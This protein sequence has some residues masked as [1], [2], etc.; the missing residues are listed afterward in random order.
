MFVDGCFWHGCPKC[1]H[2]PTANN[3]Y[4]NAKIDGNRRRDREYDRRL[5]ERGFRVLR[6]WEHQLLQTPSEVIETVKMELVI[7]TEH[8]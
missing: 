1:G 4:W 8:G 2:V 7:R 6:I 3:A 5:H